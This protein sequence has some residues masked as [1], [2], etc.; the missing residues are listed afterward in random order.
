MLVLDI[1][2]KVQNIGK[3]FEVVS[4][5]PNTKYCS[6]DCFGKTERKNI[7]G[8]K[9]NRLTVLEETETKH[10][11]RYYLCKCECGNTTIVRGSHLT[12]GAT[13]S[14]GCLVKEKLT[15]KTHGMSNTRI[16]KIYKGMLQRCF[17][18]TAK[19]YPNY[20][21]RGI[22]V[23]DEWKKDFM[24]FYN[25]AIANGYTDEL[26]IDRIN[27]NGNYCPKN[28]RWITKAEQSRNTRSNHFLTFNGKT[29][30]ICEWSREMNIDHRK[31]CKRINT[32]GWSVER[33]LTTP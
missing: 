23:C 24:N 11:E 17:C 3:I 18:K 13:K 20:G 21:G 7:I 22:I 31:I 19:A 9:F 33:T 32:Y 4:K 12:S 29:Q 25:W 28:C 6:R 16:Y 27:V 5:H 1:L 14:C 10:K 15:N 26:T 8:K 30:T 2:N